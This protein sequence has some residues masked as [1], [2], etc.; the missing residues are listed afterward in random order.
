MTDRL[1]DSLRVI[2]WLLVL[3]VTSLSGCHTSREPYLD[4]R[5]PSQ[6]LLDRSIQFHDPD[7][8]WGR[9]SIAIHWMGTKP[10]GSVSFAVDME[11]D[12]DGAF[13]MRGERK[14]H[15]IDYWVSDGVVEARVDGEL[16]VSDELRAEMVLDRDDGLFWRDYLGFLAALPM[17]LRDPDV[18]LAPNVDDAELED[19]DVLSIRAS[20]APEVGTD[21]WTFYLDPSTA[22]LVGCRFDK[23]DPARDGETIIFDGLSSVAGIQL[24]R[25]RS[26]YMN[27]DRRFLGTDQVTASGE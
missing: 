15:T 9:E 16:E 14:G 4:S 22:E 3:W 10:D 5:S 2:P 25:T 24:P 17:G 19:R 23:A 6:T 1:N 11:F 8:A 13:S 20:F 26:W 18:H 12:P 27:K 7:Q 21:T